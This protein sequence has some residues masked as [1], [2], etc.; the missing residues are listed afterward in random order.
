MYSN[1]QLVCPLKPF[2]L[3]MNW[4]NSK[5]MSF[6]YK[7]K[8]ICKGKYCNKDDIPLSLNFRN[9]LHKAVF[10]HWPNKS[11]IYWV[12]FILSLQQMVIAEKMKLCV[13]KILSFVFFLSVKKGYTHYIIRTK[14]HICIKSIRGYGCPFSMSFNAKSVK[15]LQHYEIIVS[16]KQNDGYKRNTALMCKNTENGNKYHQ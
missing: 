9:W 13:V 12:T 16:L 15:D 14:S 1:T 8:S 7:R 2:L 4:S 6:F 3:W 11:L 5:C 10:Q